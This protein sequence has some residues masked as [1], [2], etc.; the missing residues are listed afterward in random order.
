MR[1]DAAIR[2]AGPVHARRRIGYLLPLSNEARSNT[3]MS[4]QDLFQA[5]GSRPMLCDGG[6]G[7]QLIEAGMSTGECG[8]LWNVENPDAIRAIHERYADAGCELLTT[9]SFQGSRVALE[10]HG[11]KER[12]AELNKAA[13]EL[14]RQAAGDRAL[15]LADVGPFGGFLEPL[16][17]TTED[18]LLDIFM[19]QYGALKEGGADAA[20]VETM[21][22]PAEVG[23]AIKAARQTDPDWPIL[24]TLAYQKVGDGFGT[25]MGTGAAEATA[26]ALEHGASVVGANCGTELDLDD[27]RRLAE[28]L[29]R[30]A[31]G[32]PVMVQPN[33]GSPQRQGDSIV[34]PATPENMAD[35]ARQLAEAGVAIIGGCC[36]TTPDHL[37]AMGRAIRKA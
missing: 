29:L 8:I 21:S 26:L 7:T 6:M 33:A 13:A 36:G 30:Q 23:I 5:I 34:Y 10:M 37:H 20:L 14:A 4:K 1:D 17:E 19:E 11:L 27:Y 25:M 9:N 3:A 15:V 28:V 16:G 32:T 35:I 24:A 22:D 2:T 12:A 31:A 18:E